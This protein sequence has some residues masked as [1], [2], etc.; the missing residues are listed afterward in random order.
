[1]QPERMAA[2]TRAIA[3]NP[4]MR[5]MAS[6]FGPTRAIGLA[7][8]SCRISWM[9]QCNRSGGQSPRGPLNRQ[10]AKDAKE[11]PS[12]PLAS[13]ARGAAPPVSRHG[14]VGRSRGRGVRGVGEAAAPADPAGAAHRDVLASLAPW[15]LKGWAWS[16]S[17]SGR[18]HRSTRREDSCFTGCAIKVQK[19][20]V[21]TPIP[22]GGRDAP[23]DGAGAPSSYDASRGGKFRTRDIA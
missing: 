1:M 12:A 7:S 19:P 11:H 20:F 22:R 10:G 15:R 23:A 14:S 16:S 9:F 5:F 4:P 3:S 2:A 13:E 17:A 6:S 8:E 21:R 18:L